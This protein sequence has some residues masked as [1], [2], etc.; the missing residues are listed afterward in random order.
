MSA[1]LNETVLAMKHAIEDAPPL[2]NAGD[3]Q[4]DAQGIIVGFAG[5]MLATA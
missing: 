3:L 1:E 5:D 2:T 4:T